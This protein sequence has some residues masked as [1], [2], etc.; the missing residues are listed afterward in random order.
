MMMQQL[1]DHDAAIIQAMFV[2]L[3]AYVLTGEHIGIIVELYHR[4]ARYGLIDDA[5]LICVQ[6]FYLLTLQGDEG[7]YLGTLVVEVG[8]DALLVG[9]RGGRNFYS[10]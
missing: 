1:L 2:R 3:S 5:F 10:L 4:F 7:I 9:E 6:G 8:G